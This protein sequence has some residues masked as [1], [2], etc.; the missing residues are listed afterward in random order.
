MDEMATIEYIVSGV[1]QG[2][3][4]RYFALRTA[5]RLGIAGFVGNLPTGQVQVVASSDDDTLTQFGHLLEE[6]P[7][8]SRV[9]GV[10]RVPFPDEDFDGF[11]V[12]Y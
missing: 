10:Q 6:G 4:Y 8:M 3:G 5:Q 11:T 7:R 9:T 1:V 12:R 2:V